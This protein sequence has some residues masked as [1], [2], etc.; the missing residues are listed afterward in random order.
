MQ[1]A[2]TSYLQASLQ[3]TS[4]T[5]LFERHQE[6]KLSGCQET[7]S[8]CPNKLGHLPGSMPA[9]HP[10]RPGFGS[11]AAN[12]NFNHPF[13]CHEVSALI[14]GT[15]ADADPDCWAF[16]VNLLGHTTESWQ[17]VENS[18]PE[19]VWKGIST[20]SCTGFKKV[21]PTL[22][23]FESISTSPPG[24]RS[25][26]Q[27]GELFQLPGLLRQFCLDLCAGNL[28]GTAFAAGLGGWGSTT[29]TI[30]RSQVARFGCW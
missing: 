16:A 21:M 20:W 1:Y 26:A 12:L 13:S 15:R 18:W 5:E 19:N 29:D 22:N 23:H 10:S 7:T 3:D 28:A 24:A 2:L 9:V 4:W 27:P 11:S 25:T 14:S 17:L 30:V 8:H 6:P